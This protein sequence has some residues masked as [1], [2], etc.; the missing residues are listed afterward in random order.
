MLGAD[1][2]VPERARFAGGARER[3][4]RALVEP[5]RPRLALRRVRDEALLRCLLADPESSS[6]LRPAAA[7]RPCR[8]YEVVD[9][10][11]RATAHAFGKLERRGQPLERVGV[12]T[13]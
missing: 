5:L 10:L 1:V 3:G 13:L 9:E 12:R 4:A 2:V 6:N 7:R 11:V 8:L